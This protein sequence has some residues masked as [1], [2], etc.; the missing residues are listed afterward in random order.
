MKSNIHRYEEWSTLVGDQ[1]LPIM[2]VD[3]DAFDRNV[4][5]FVAIARDHQKTL[6]PATKS[7]RVPALIRRIADLGGA[8]VRGWMCYSAREAR[9]LGDQGFDDLLVAY[10]HVQSDDVYQ[11][12]ELA[13]EGKTVTLMID[14]PAHAE[15]LASL[16]D[17][18]NQTFPLRICIDIDASLKKLGQHLGVQR[19]SVRNL[20]ELRQLIHTIKRKP[21]LKLVGAMTYEAQV[22][23]LADTS[24]HQRLINPVIRQI[25]KSSIV[26]LRDYRQ[27]IR[28]LFASEQVEMEIFNGGGSGSLA[29]TAT[30]TALTEITAGSGFLQSHLFDQY[31]ANHCEPALF[32]ALP[33]T[34]IPQADRVT[35]HSG[36][37]I[38]SGSPGV[39][40]Q[41][42]VFLPESVKVDSRE[43]FG[44]VQTPLI[45]PTDL[46]GKLKIG[47]PIFFRPSKAGEIA[48]R[49]NEYSLFRDGEIVEHVNTYRGFGKCFY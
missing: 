6:R 46:Q 42:T 10:P 28:D 39:D 11:A 49:F 24:P 22:A 43:G 33:I 44:E 15:T 8:T 20:D 7:I 14:A 4:E 21:Q 12:N 19:S 26:W 3:L 16:C 31:L 47:D 29:E 35:C 17:D 9:F 37:F 2:L 34:R 23:G 13:K 36:G 25:K 45:V 5:R 40:R 32:F 1:T 18:L 27:K 30:H 48:E 41:P 38:A